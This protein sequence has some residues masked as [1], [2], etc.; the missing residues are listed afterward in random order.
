ME[1]V[2]KSI[3]KFGFFDKARHSG[4]MGCSHI[5]EL[6]CQ[7][8][9]RIVVD[10]ATGLMWQQSGSADSMTYADAAAYIHDLNRKH[11]AGYDDW[12][13]P[14][15]EEAMSLMEPKMKGGGLCIN[16]V[17]DNSQRSIWTADKVS[18]SAA[19][20]TIFTFGYCYTIYVDDNRYIRAVR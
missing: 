2:E 13:L 11:F 20:V 15:L 16:P 14:T 1:E 9:H 7:G 10:H 19:W 17:F 5:Y 8:N 18:A 4:G 3:K 6:R 12:R